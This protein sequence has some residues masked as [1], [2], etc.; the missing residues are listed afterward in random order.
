MRRIGIVSGLTL[1]LFVTI[2]AQLVLAHITPPVILISDREAVVGMLQGA[3]RFFVREVRLSDEE[4]AAIQKQWG[5]R[6]EEGFYRFY[7]GRD[8]E[9]RLI[10]AVIFLTDFTIHGP[11]RIAVGI[12]SDGKVKDAK[13][14]ELTEETFPWLKPLLDQHLTQ[15]YI[16]RSS[17][18]SFT[19]SERFAKAHLA[20]MPRFYAEIVASLIQRAVILYDMTFL[21][22][23]P[24][25]F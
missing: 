3:K 25:S 9:E 21:R 20:S 15:D 2:E 4:R 24:Q 11:V 23:E 18:A 1:A 17:R 22:R 12:G 14:V 19:L 10:G 6:P 13:V 16:G 7:L 8:Q 5:W